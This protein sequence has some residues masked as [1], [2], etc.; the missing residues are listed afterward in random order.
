MKHLT[1]LC[2]NLFLIAFAYAEKIPYQFIKDSY[3]FDL[4]EAAE[5]YEDSHSIHYHKDEHI[6]CGAEKDKNCFYEIGDYYFVVQPFYDDYDN[7]YVS[8]IE[9]TL[10]NG[11]RGFARLDDLKNLQA[12]ESIHIDF[13]NARKQCWVSADTFEI[14]NSKSQDFLLKKE[15]YWVAS[16]M[17]GM[18]EDWQDDVSVPLISFDNKSLYMSSYASSDAKFLIESC[19]DNGKDL[20]INVYA[21][22]EAYLGGEETYISK[23]SKPGKYKITVN[24][25]GDYLRLYDN[26]S[27]TY[28]DFAYTEQY[29]KIFEL[30][31]SIARNETID[32][33][34]IIWPRHADGSRDYDA[35]GNMTADA[36]EN[37]NA[38]HTSEKAAFPEVA[39]FSEEIAEAAESAE[40]ETDFAVKTKTENNDGDFDFPFIQTGLGIILV[41]VLLSILL[42]IA[43][44]RKCG[45]E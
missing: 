8:C 13:N 22:H 36:N 28:L 11:Q 15:P 3:L 40:S 33:S 1:A 27:D 19:V 24:F 9:I 41:I 43:R 29:D 31:K 18:G 35:D 34:D 37:P 38:A 16:W 39:E 14:L 6:I 30:K 17:S 2:L 21:D 4:H 7:D 26:N 44:K 25:D 42:A 45:K 10:D 20:E 23:Y 32:L 12:C 5:L